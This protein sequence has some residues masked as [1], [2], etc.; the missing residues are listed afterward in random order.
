MKDLELVQVVF[1]ATYKCNSNCVFCYN[2]WKHDYER[3]PEMDLAQIRTVLS[4]LPKVNRFVISGGEPLLR[5]DLEEIIIESRKYTKFI[6]VL[7]SGILVNDMV[8]QMLKEH[9]I[10]VQ[11]PIH[12]MEKTHNE[13]T[14]VKDGYKKTLKGIAWLKKAGVKFATTAVAN[15]KNIDELEKI[16]QLGI[17]LGASEIQVIRFMPGGEGMANDDLM[18]T[19]EDYIRMLE[20]LNSVCGKYRIFGASGAPN[21]PCRFPDEKYRYIHIGNCGAGIDWIVI[22]PSGRVRICNHSPTILGNL[23]ENNFSEIWNH[24]I[25]RAFRANEVIPE[26]C[27]GCD[28]MQDCRGGCRAVAETYYGSLYAPDPLM[29]R[30]NRINRPPALKNV[31]F[32]S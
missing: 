28:K 13:L 18:L 12:G 1:E 8:A 4:K 21:I 17:A 10:F 29:K 6:S 9:D 30:N 31:D 32:T 11:I 22:D 15:R 20:I 2:C 26:E 23:L 19:D 5:K 27:S 24:H 25:L 7:T 3:L 16:F 14:G